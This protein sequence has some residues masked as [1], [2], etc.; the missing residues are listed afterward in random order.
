M[1]YWSILETSNPL[2]YS[3]SLSLS[4]FVKLPYKPNKFLTGLNPAFLLCALHLSDCS[5]G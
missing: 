2:R 5:I 4:A 1:E 3:F